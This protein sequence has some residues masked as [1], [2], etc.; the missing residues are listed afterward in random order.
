MAL[1]AGPGPG[2][3]FQDQIDT[4][5]CFGKVIML[6]EQVSFQYD[7]S[8]GVLPEVS[9]TGGNAKSRPR[10]PDFHLHMLRKNRDAVESSQS[11]ESIQ[12]SHSRVVIACNVCM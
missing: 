7:F 3:L 10:A 1:T 2:F 4:C 6:W 5:R 11:S 8:P 12:V 9:S